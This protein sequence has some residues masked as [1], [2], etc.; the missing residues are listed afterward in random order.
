MPLPLRRRK[1]CPHNLAHTSSSQHCSSNGQGNPQAHPTSAHATAATKVHR[2]T[3]YS[4]GQHFGP[5][6]NVYQPQQR[7]SYGGRGGG[8]RRGGRRN[9]NSP[10]SNTIKTHLNLWYCYRCGYGVVHEGAHCPYVQP[11]NFQ[12]SYVKRDGAHIIEGACMK[13]QYKTLPDGTEGQQG[14]DSGTEYH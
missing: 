11:G 6:P 10:Y 2:A 7:Q 14:M 4:G 5:S 13:A 8:H 12:I 3:K 1:C 9:Q